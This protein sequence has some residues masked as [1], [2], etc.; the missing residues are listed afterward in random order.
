MKKY[1]IIA[2]II[3]LFS[4]GLVI[5]FVI[6]RSS[7]NIVK[8]DSRLIL[9]SLKNEGFLITQSNIFDQEVTIQKEQGNW[10]DIFWGQTVTARGVIKVSVGVDLNQLSEEDIVVNSNAIEITIPK[11]TIFSTDI[12]G[13]ITV[14]NKQGILKRIFNSDDGYNSAYTALK[15]EAQSTLETETLY[16]E[17]EENAKKQ[18]MKFIQF[19][20]P[21]KSITILFK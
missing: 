14:Q 4:F 2:G 19:I 17:M 12:L 10:R 6:N 1:F 20:E 21:L 16:K 9:T 8:V 3:F 7:K 15:Q 18:I 13:D 11:P 5:G